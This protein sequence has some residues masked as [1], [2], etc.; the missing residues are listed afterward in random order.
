M[1]GNRDKGDSN[2]RWK[3]EIA[4]LTWRPVEL[5]GQLSLWPPHQR[6][7][8]AS[9]QWHVAR[10]LMIPHMY[11]PWLKN[12][13]CPI[14]IWLITVSHCIAVDCWSK[15][16]VLY[17]INYVLYSIPGGSDGRESACNEGDLSLIPGLGK[18]PGGGHGTPLQY[19]CLKNP[20]G[21]RSLAGYSLWG[22]KEL[23]MTE[24]LSTQTHAINIYF[25]TQ[26]CRK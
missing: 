21:Q 12:S 6:E 20:H 4:L 15:N 8:K 2:L 5:I 26:V 18:S 1:L 19:S 24:W 3:V 11:E 22:R 10:I 17:S 13:K 7:S 14:I 23:D 16:D 9:N 25:Y